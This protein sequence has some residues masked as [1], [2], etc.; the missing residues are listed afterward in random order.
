MQSVYELTEH[1]R[2]RLDEVRFAHCLCVQRRAEQLALL[3]GEDREKA[4]IAGLLHDICKVEPLEAQLQIIRE[5]DIILDD[6]TLG[7]S[8]LWHAVAGEA[9]CRHELGIDDGEILSAIRWHTTG[10]AGMTPLE[11]ILYLADL[12]SEDRDFPGVKKLRTLANKAPADCMRLW[13]QKT[14]SGLVD[15]Q[16]P[17]VADAWGA[18]NDYITRPAG[19]VLR[20]AVTMGGKTE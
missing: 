18:Y 1:A 11:E 13:L 16:M 10:H 2:D 12:T 20:T 19:A 17:I 8:Q 7:Q 4:S 14:L 5:H 6:F 9:Y 3:H 15:R